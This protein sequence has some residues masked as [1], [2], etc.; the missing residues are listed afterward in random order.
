MD[1]EYQKIHACPSYEEDTSYVQ[2]KHGRKT[3]YTRHR[4]FR[5]PYHLY[6]RLKK[7]FNGSQEH[8]NALILLTGE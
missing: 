7:A 3:I 8:D 2:L 5:K 4:R 1:M 6:W